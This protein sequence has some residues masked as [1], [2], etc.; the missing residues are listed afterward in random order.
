MSSTVKTFDAAIANGEALSAAV[1]L[2]QAIPIGILVP[3]S[4]T[5]A[6]LTVLASVDDQ[7][8]SNV[9]D[10]AGT[11]LTIT[12]GGSSRYI[13]LDQTLFVGFVNIKLRSG[14]S[15]T[16]VNQTG[17]KTLKIVTKEA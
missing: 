16:P 11:E 12:V 3:A 1:A 5:A 13:A 9:Y 15:G 10:A 14:T 8:W 6:N 2:G 4:W 7:N 17:A